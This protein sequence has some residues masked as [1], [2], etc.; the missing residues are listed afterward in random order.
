MSSRSFRTNQVITPD[1]PRISARARLALLSAIVA[2]PA[3]AMFAQAPTPARTTDEVIVLD[4]LEVTERAADAAIPL[5][6]SLA[7][8]ELAGVAGGTRLID[9][10]LVSRGRVGTSADVLAFTPG[11]FATPPSGG[12]DGIKISARGSGIARSA[13][14]FFR[15]GV[16]FSFDGLPVTGPGGTPYELFE[17]YG[18]NYTEV[19]LGGNAFDFGAIQ[20]GG[21]VNYVTRTGY[22]ASPLEG[23]VDVGSFGYRKFQISSGQVIGNADYFISVTSAQADGYQ[24]NARSSS[25][26]FAGNFG[27]RFNDKVSTRVFLRHRTTENQNPGSLSLNQLRDNTKQA[28]ADNVVGRVDR[29]QPGSTWIGNKTNIQLTP[30]SRLEL[31]LVHHNAPIVIQ[32]TPSPGTSTNPNAQRERSDWN[33]RDITTIAKYTR[34]DT[35]FDRESKTTVAAVFSYSYDAD[36]N[37]FAYNPNVLV[38]E[39]AFGT[40]L[41]TAN[42]DGSTD[43]SLRI[44]NEL[45]LTDSLWL[46]TGLSL[47]YLRRASEVT[48]F[49]PA[50]TPAAPPPGAAGTSFDRDDYY[51][52]PRLGLRYDVTKDISLFGNITRSIEA[53]NSWQLNRGSAGNVNFHDPIEDQKAWAAEIGGRVKHGAFEGSLSVYRSHVT[54]ELLTVPIDPD[55]LPLGTRTFNG[56]DTYKQ[57]LEVGLLT[58]IWNENGF[59]TAPSA[60]KSTRVS[61]LQSF[62]YNDFGYRGQNVFPAGDPNADADELPGVPRYQY[63]GRLSIEHSSGFYLNFSAIHAS[64]YYADF[65]NNLEVPSYTTFD[66]GVGYESPSGHWSVLI[67]VRNVGDKGYAASAGPVFN[68]TPT[69]AT[70]QAADGRAVYGA[71]TLKF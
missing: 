52:A 64:T 8:V 55:N 49:N 45:G 63:Q 31:G 56:P 35:L 25:E 62:N 6:A 48:F 70:F 54:D 21:S 66:I 26:G 59:F 16:L 18:L 38:G 27:Y 46:N 57:G 2:L 71:F 14:N 34:E 37:S 50:L 47:I 43:A 61:F 32:P 51:L 42:Y 5:S 11:V 4:K 44:G 12:G 33:F 28:N 68:G 67:D 22:D 65:A 40:L 24:P 10:S 39:R 36:V 58:Q 15:N 60:E 1:R 19:L 41:K 23:R 69:T 17:T 30:D 3:S 9:N 53:P 13:G 29:L 7:A 20:L